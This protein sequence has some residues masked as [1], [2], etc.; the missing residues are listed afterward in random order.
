MRIPCPNCG[1]RDVREFVYSGDA[2]VK[3][4]DANAPDA[5][6]RFVTYVYER[7]NPAGPHRELWYHSFG[8]QAWL[9]VTRNTANHEILEVKPAVAASEAKAVTL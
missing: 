9:V 6:E 8:C 4:P 5:V 7:D 1:S 2:S 3:R